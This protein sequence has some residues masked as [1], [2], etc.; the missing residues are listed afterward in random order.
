EMSVSNTLVLLVL[1]LSAAVA[2]AEGIAFHQTAL[3]PGVESHSTP[4]PDRRRLK[5][6][7]N[8]VLVVDLSQDHTLYAKNSDQEMPIASITK[9]MTAMVVLDAG[10]SPTEKIIITKEDKDRLKYSRSQLPIGSVLARGKLL[11]I[12]LMASEN[13]AAAALA[14]TFPSGRQAFIEKMNH[15]AKELGMLHTTF[16]DPTGL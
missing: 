11:H 9:L 7:S 14:R 12:A 16:T 15:K 10:L 8:S 3:A 4:T 6:K 13:R 1:L 2:G 5:L